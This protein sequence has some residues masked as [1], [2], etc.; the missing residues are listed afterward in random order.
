MRLGAAVTDA[1]SNAHAAL[2]RVLM[3]TRTGSMMPPQADPAAISQVLNQQTGQSGETPR[4]FSTAELRAALAE[5]MLKL[6][7]QPL[8]RL[9][10]RVPIGVEALARL[11]HPKFGMLAAEQFIPQMEAANLSHLLTEAMITQAMRDNCTY[12]LTTL[13]LRIGLNVPLN[14]LMMEEV[15]DLLESQRQ[16]CAIPASDII[17]ELTETQPVT[18]YASLRNVI[19]RLRDIGYRVSIDDASPAMVDLDR[20]IGLGFNT[21]KF[22]KSVVQH[23]ARDKDCR[24]FIER[25]GKRARA[26]NMLTIAEGIEDVE[27]H[28]LM[29]DVG[30][31]SGQG[32][33][34]AH[35]L[36]PAA[37]KPWLD[38]WQR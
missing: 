13:G 36:L 2:S 3:A 30:I 26:S 15:F 32:Y 24:A 28:D 7:Y 4:Q 10:D 37:V 27:T 33:L 31:D 23:A 1:A 12:G 20:L 6:R 22:D 25:V 5:P 35:P 11:D 21:L 34:I 38:T 29:R 14:V 17:V 16:K 18:D 9:A 19:R 8:V